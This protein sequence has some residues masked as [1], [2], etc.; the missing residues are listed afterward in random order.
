MGFT[1]GTVTVTDPGSFNGNPFDYSISIVDGLANPSTGF[2]TQQILKNRLQADTYSLQ[3]LQ[4]I[5]DLAGVSFEI[6]DI[7]IFPTV[8]PSIPFDPTRPTFIRTDFGTIADITI[9]PAPSVGTLPS[10]TAPN[11]PTFSPSIG[12]ITIPQPP[13]Q[14]SIASPGDPP[15]APILQFPTLQPISYPDEP[16]LTA[17]T[18]PEFGGVEIP[19]FEPEFPSIDDPILNSHLDWTEPTYT[20]E[21]IDSVIAKIQQMLDGGL[22]IDPDVEQ[23]IVDRARD[24]EDRL[25]RQAVSQAMDEIAGRGYSQ[26]PGVLVERIDN[27]REEGLIKK[28]SLNREVMIKI[29]DEELANMRLAVQQGIAAEQLF[30]Q[31]FLAAVERLFEV[32]KLN[33]Q[34]QIEIYNLLVTLFNARMQEVQIRASVFETQVRAAL[35]EVEIFK[36]LVDAERAKAEVNKSL[37]DAYVA[38]IEARKVF[39]DIY[40]AQVRAV[41]VRAEIYATDIQAYKGKVE[42]YAAEIGAEK[43]K[44]DAYE[45]QV[46]GEAAKATIIESEARAY[47]AQIE[48]IGSGVTAEVAALRGEVSKIE[49]EIQAYLAEVQGLTAQSEVQLKRIQSSVAGF[50]A[51]TQKYAA[52]AGIIESEN[53]VVVAAWDAANRTNIAFFEAQVAKFRTQ[54]EALSRQAEIALGALRATGDIASTVTA[55]ALAAMHLG[56]TVNGGGNV[57]GSGSQ[58]VSFGESISQSQSSSCSNSNSLSISATTNN[59][60]QF[61][62]PL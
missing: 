19:T 13:V 46:R 56:A 57:S 10:V 4:T 51:D 38:Q 48:G 12:S 59:P 25:V 22:A 32:E 29:F 21:I 35:A 39:V 53:R 31:L 45:A 36:A 2:V 47:A 44:F 50:S 20:R 14:G 28:L 55:G 30:I 54:V 33:V 23:G 58:S 62:C 5:A 9:P 60:V 26:P 11:I 34:W 61:D 42:A 43:L 41:A 16:Q 17:V 3:A 40:E 15:G 6:P 7:D 37:V 8:D 27:I 52:D 49:A 1:D 24:R 18:I